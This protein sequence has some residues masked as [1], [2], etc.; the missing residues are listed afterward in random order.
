MKIILDVHLAMCMCIV[1][2]K[3]CATYLRMNSGMGIIRAYYNNR[4]KFE[5]ILQSITGNFKIKMIKNNIATYVA[6]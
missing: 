2:Y 5:E 4:V 1:K 3:Q 6:K